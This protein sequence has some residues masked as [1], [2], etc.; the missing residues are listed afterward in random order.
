MI[1]RGVCDEAVNITCGY[2]QRHTPE[3]YVDLRE[4]A[5]T[6]AYVVSIVRSW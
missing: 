4:A 6:L 2:Y 3:E 1:S 5:N